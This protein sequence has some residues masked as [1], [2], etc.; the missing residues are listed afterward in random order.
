[1]LRL[2]LE[3]ASWHTEGWRYAP[4]TV[5]HTEHENSNI[6]SNAFLLPPW[7]DRCREGQK[8]GHRDTSK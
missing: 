5:S 3:L 6:L 1:M 4:D 2:G 7:N 8:V